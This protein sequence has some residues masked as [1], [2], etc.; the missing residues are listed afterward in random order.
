MNKV[1]TLQFVC[2]SGLPGI[3]PMAL[4]KVVA[5]LREVVATLR[6]DPLRDSHRDSRLPKAFGIA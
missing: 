1:A 3:I 6:G 5:T 2:H 4:K